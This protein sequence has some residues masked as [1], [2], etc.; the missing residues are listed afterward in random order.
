M[1]YR[2]YPQRFHH[3]HPELY[4]KPDAIMVVEADRVVRIFINIP[5]TGR[6]ILQT[7]LP[8]V[9]IDEGLE[10]A[11]NLLNLYLLSKEFSND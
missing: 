9:S 1:S 4:G 3:L 7:L 10:A 8:R 2:R 6:Q 11:Q 5:F